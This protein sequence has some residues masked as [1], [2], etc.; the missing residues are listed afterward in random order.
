MLQHV[1]G[2]CGGERAGFRGGRFQPRCRGFCARPLLDGGAEGLGGPQQ[3]L[4]PFRRATG[5]GTLVQQGIEGA[6]ERAHWCPFRP[7]PGGQ[8][9]P[10]VLGQRHGFAHW[11]EQL[12]DRGDTDRVVGTR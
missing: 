9:P 4:D 3:Q 11:P 1:A 12:L 2:L 7:V 10:L 5:D 8:L 6:V